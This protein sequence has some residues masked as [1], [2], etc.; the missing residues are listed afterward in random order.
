MAG[1]K[2]VEDTVTARLNKIIERGR[3][4]R[5]FMVRVVRPTYQNAQRKRFMTENQSAGA[6]WAPLN[7]KYAKYK[8]TKFKDFPGG[9]TKINIATGKMFNTLVLQE[10]GSYSEIATEFSYILAFDSPYMKYVDEV[11][12]IMQ[13]RDEFYKD[14]KKQLVTWLRGD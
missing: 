12:P 9:G 3:D 1:L 6:Q 11:R 5:A 4:S 13:F 10:S 8:L 7:P 14:L 2:K